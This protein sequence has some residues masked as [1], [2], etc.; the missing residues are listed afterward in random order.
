[1]THVIFHDFPGL[2]N[3]LP[4]FHDFPDMVDSDLVIVN[5]VV[6]ATDVVVVLH[7]MRRRRR[8]LHQLLVTSQLFRCLHEARRPLQ[9][10]RLEV[11]VQRLYTRARNQCPATAK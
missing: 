6:A 5:V 3:G 10:Q 8:M 4:K 1:M 7:L 2:E 9:C 11:R